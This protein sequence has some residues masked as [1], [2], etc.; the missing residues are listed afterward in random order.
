M[1][2]AIGL[3]STEGTGP[4]VSVVIGLPLSGGT[5]PVGL[6]IGLPPTGERALR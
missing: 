3:P 5:G 2:L 6:A 1:S 4:V